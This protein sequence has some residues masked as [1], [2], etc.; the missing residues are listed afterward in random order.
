MNLLH[1]LMNMNRNKILVRE[2]EAMEQF[3]EDHRE[4]IAASSGITLAGK[5]VN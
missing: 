3:L 5:H 2:F 1:S 4:I